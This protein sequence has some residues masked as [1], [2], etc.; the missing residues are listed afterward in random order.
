MEMDS[1]NIISIIPEPVKILSR[2]GNFNLNKNTLILSNSIAKKSAEFLNQLLAPATGFNLLMRELAQVEEIDNVIRLRII[3]NEKPLMH[4]GYN[5]DISQNMIDISASTS[6]GIFYGIQTLRQL[7]PPEIESSNP[8]DVEWSMPCVKIEDYPRFSWRGFMLD[9]SRH[10]FG[11]KIVKKMLDLMALLKMNVFHWHLTDDQGWRLE[12]KK[13]PRL[14][15]IGSKR[16]RARLR[17]RVRKSDKYSDD[18]QYSGHYSREDLREIINH[19]SERHITI[20]PEIDVPGHTT[21]VLASYPELSCTGGP[22]EVSTRFAIHKD[23]LCIGKEKVFEFILNVLDEVM[24]IFPSEIIHIGGDEVPKERWKNCS[25]CQNRIKEENLNNEEELQA[26]F[27]NKMSRYISSL[28]R[29]PMGWNEILN[30]D[31]VENALCQ[32][33]TPNLKELLDHVR[34]GRNVVMSETGYV[35][36]NYGYKF[37]S[38]RK[39]YEYEPIPNELEKR[40]HDRI[41]GIEACLWTEFIS[42]LKNLELLTFPRL[43]AIAETGWALI[44]KKNFKSFLNRLE[45]YLKRL[46]FHGIAYAHENEYLIEE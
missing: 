37:T 17:T 31:L 29:R 6:A 13:Y 30:E 14:V 24:D 5:L 21:A 32:Y 2:K 25:H 33:W 40:Y 45:I 7:F 10:F 11:K 36:L 20:V 18:V 46:D 15:E 22:F 43:I 35:Y 27:I 19:A 1:N 26:Y 3:T 42:D 23:V 12:I 16:K 44:D 39:S 38:L 41:K 34:T 28:G 9:E 4:E 8:L